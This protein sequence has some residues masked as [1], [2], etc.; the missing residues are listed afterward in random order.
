METFLDSV[1]RRFN[2][3]NETCKEGILKTTDPVY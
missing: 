1:I 3:L 2:L